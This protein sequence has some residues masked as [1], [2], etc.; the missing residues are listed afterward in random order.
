M[1]YWKHN[2][3]ECDFM[4]IFTVSYFIRDILISQMEGKNKNHYVNGVSD[5]KVHE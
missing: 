2:F 1:N 5:Q 3:S 4:A